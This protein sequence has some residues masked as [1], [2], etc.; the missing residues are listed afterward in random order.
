VARSTKSAPAVFGSKSAAVRAR[1]T[2]GDT[3]S[4]A[5]AAVGIGYAFA[6]GIAA[7]F[8]RPDGS[9]SY[10]ETAANRRPTRAVRVVGNAVEIRPASGGVIRVDTATGAVTRRARG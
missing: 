4:A 5:A 3:V 1:L 10:A 7:R 6:Y 8:P 2:A 9:G